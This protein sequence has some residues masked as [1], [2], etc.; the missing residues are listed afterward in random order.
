MIPVDGSVKPRYVILYNF[1]S[2]HRPSGPNC[3]VPDL[4]NYTPICAKAPTAKY[5][6][7]QE[8]LDALYHSEEVRHVGQAGG[9]KPVYF[10]T[11]ENPAHFECSSNFSEQP[12]AMPMPS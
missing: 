8:Q 10:E 4:S 9:P 11:M 2:S 7:P 3:Q 5:L 1:W 12:V 6:L